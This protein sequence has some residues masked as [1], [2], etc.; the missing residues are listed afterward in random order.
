MATEQL[1]GVDYFPIETDMKDDDKVFA[2]KYRF[3]LDADGVYDNTAAFAAYGRFIEL[4]ASIY[5][6]GFALRLSNQKCLQLSQRLGLTLPEFK[7]FTQACV[8]VGLFDDGLWARDGVLTSRGIQHRY[9]HAVKRR[10]GDIPAEFKA[11]VIAPSECE[12]DADVKAASKGGDANTVQTLCEHDASMETQRSGENANNGSATT[13][14]NVD[15]MP[16]GKAH[17]KEKNRIEKNIKE[18][19]R[20]PRARRASSSSSSMSLLSECLEDVLGSVKPIDSSY[21]LQC[22]STTPTDGRVFNDSEGKTHSTPWDALCARYSTATDGQSIGDFAREVSKKCPD[23]CKA[24]ASQVSQCFALL[25]S[26]LDKFNPSKCANPL[27]LA[28]TIL[29]DRVIEDD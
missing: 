15:T 14:S 5:R 8:D 24:S 17:I 7:D 11:Y 13:P 18:E 6:E 20:K 19:D 23:G 29:K 4:L 16:A 12:H 10:K 27:P 21:P 28:L 2:L 22:F 26:S 9:F 1:M 25:C 3:G